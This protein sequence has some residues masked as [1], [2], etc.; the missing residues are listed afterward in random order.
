MKFFSAIVVAALAL[1]IAAAPLPPR[2]R[3]SD[4]LDS[5]LVLR[6]PNPSPQNHHLSNQMN[7]MHL[8]SGHASTAGLANVM[9]HGASNVKS[10]S[11]GGRKPRRSLQIDEDEDELDEY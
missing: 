7:Q 8:A 11:H 4:N 2:A 1:S 3:S 6:S 10:A 9:S 5:E